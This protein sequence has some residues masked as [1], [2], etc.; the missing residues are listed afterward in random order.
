M[1]AA[2]TR[3]LCRVVR[4]LRCV[5]TNAPALHGRSILAVVIVIFWHRLTLICRM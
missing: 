1:E 2:V 3:I 5:N 4:K